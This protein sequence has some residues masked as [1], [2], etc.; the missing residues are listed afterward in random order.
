MMLEAKLFK[1]EWVWVHVWY[2]R[3]FLSHA[4]ASIVSLFTPVQNIADAKLN[5]IWRNMKIIFCNQV[6]WTPTEIF[7]VLQHDISA[8]ESWWGWWV[9]DKAAGN[10]KMLASMYMDGYVCT[11][12]EHV[13]LYV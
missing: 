9:T 6:C 1:S 7:K 2:C 3:C 12:C 8:S 11:M 13:C 4:A 5:L 10:D